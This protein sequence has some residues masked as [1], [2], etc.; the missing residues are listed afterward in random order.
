MEKLNI[1]D[2]NWEN[3]SAIVNGKGSKQREVYF[4]T[5]CK[6]I[7]IQQR[8]LSI[9]TIRWALKRLA[10][11][12]EVEANVYPHCFRHT[13]ACQLLD[14]GAPLDFIQAMLGHEKASTT[15]IYAQLRGERNENSTVGFFSI[16]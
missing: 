13:Y 6:P 10:G 5:E 15:Q 7:H 16:S 4:T 3:S 14:N 8:R 2:L 9:P 1:D 11:R 12:G